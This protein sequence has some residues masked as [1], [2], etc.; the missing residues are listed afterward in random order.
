MEALEE[1]L[2][3]LR[4]GGSLFLKLDLRLLVHSQQLGLERDDQES[5]FE[6]S[7]SVWS[8][9]LEQLGYSEILLLAVELPVQ[10]VPAELQ[11]VVNQ[12]P[13]AYQDRIAGRLDGTVARVRLAMDTIDTVLDFSSR[14]QVLQQFTGGSA[15]REQM[16]SKL[17]ATKSE[18][19]TPVK[20]V[21]LRVANGSDGNEARSNECLMHAAARDTIRL[22][23]TCTPLACEH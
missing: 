8:K 3:R 19:A 13:E 15:T 1:A 4:E 18:R 20:K 11:G 23:A 12:L 7:L 17:Y 10:G 22:R 16:S 14:A 6:A 21:D 5:V 2:E 9:V